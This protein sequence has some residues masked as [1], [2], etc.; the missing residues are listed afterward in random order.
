MEIWVVIGSAIAAT[1]TATAIIV[2]SRLQA[3][4]ERKERQKDRDERQIERQIELKRQ[5][6]RERINP[7]IIISTEIGSLIY[8]FKQ[9]SVNPV[10]DVVKPTSQLYTL[11]NELN[12]IV[13]NKMWP[14]VASSRGIDT[15][16]G[17]KSVSLL[18]KVQ[19]FLKII[20]DKLDELSIEEKKLRSELVELKSKNQDKSKI[21]KLGI[22]KKL[23]ELYGKPLNEHL[24]DNQRFNKLYYEISNA[25]TYLMNSCYG[26]I[27][28]G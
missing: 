15:R 3:R 6:I 5:L 18:G 17:D 8:Q 11:I 26:L 14:A 24:K 19:E 21:D 22:D 10:G 2:S 27:E 20:N 25:A 23:I 13:N 4:G 28:A 12:M 7:M 9:L 16:L 1:I